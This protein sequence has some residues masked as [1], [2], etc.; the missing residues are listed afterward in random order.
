MEVVKLLLVMMGS[1]LFLLALYLLVVVITKKLS[2]ETKKRAILKCIKN[3]DA[4]CQNCNGNCEKFAD[5]LLAGKQ[6][7]EDC[8]KI[9][10]NVKDELKN[11]LDIRPVADGRLVAHVMCKGGA[12]AKDQYHYLGVNTCNYSNKLFD[13]L[14]VC[15]KGCQGCMDCATV[16]PTNAIYKN[17]AG[18]AEVD[19]SM[20]I[21]CGECVKKCPDNIIRLIDINQDIVVACNQR[22]TKGSQSNVKDFCSTGCTMC[23]ECV[24][25]CPTQAL[26]FEN[27]ILKFDRAKCISCVRCV[28]ACPNSTISRL[29]NDFEKN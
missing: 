29:L 12:R 21:G 6:S 4:N 11:L 10:N 24:K 18:V 27:G 28:Y 1:L 13:G 26:F 3:D 20:C 14:K 7:I 17:K 2:T 16:C 5:N 23:G 22:G 19:R 8:P 25:I 15:K 9:S